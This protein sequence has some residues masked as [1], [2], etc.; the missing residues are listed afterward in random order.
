MKR[1]IARLIARL[2]DYEDVL[3][4]AGLALVTAGVWL[5]D[6]SLGLIAAGVILLLTV[7][8]MTRWIK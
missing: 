5:H 8:P 4:F 7:R 6:A 2:P 3:Y 1:L